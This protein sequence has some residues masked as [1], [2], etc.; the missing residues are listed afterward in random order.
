MA[1]QQDIRLLHVFGSERAC[2]FMFKL[3]QP[4]QYRHP[5]ICHLFVTL[6]PSP[7]PR[8]PRG[9]KSPGLLHPDYQAG[10]TFK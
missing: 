7:A 9:L 6:T 10:L 3:G 8:K 5:L 4:F 1:A 2:R